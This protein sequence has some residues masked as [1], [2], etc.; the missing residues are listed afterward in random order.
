MTPLETA[1]EILHGLDVPHALEDGGL[2]FAGPTG[3]GRIVETAGGALRVRRSLAAAPDDPIVLACVAAWVRARVMLYGGRAL[4]EETCGVRELAAMLGRTP[5]PAPPRPVIAVAVGVLGV[6]LPRL[7][8]PA[9]LRL[10]PQAG[11]LVDRARATYLLTANRHLRATTGAWSDGPSLVVDPVPADMERL[12]G[13]IHAIGT[14]LRV[15]GDE[16]IARSYLEMVPPRVPAA[17]G[18][19]A[20]P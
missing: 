2:A 1:R 14:S 8:G 7:D 4:V 3:P 5:L 19:N 16:A 9:I 13:E 6:A 18:G 17:S 11:G 10:A 20:S 12:R 15:L